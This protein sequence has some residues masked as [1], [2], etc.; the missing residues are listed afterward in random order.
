MKQAALDFQYTRGHFKIPIMP[1]HAKNHL[2]GSGG[3]FWH[4]TCKLLCWYPGSEIWGYLS[5]ATPMLLALCTSESTKVH[6]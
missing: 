1:S 6:K 3:C 2:Y 5:A 4:K